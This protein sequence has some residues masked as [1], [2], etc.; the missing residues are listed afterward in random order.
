MPNV[1]SPQYDV[2]LSHNS[3]DKEIVTKIAE[4]LEDTAGL[5]SW[6]DEWELVPGKRWISGLKK[7]ITDV[8][9]IAVFIGNY[10]YGNWQG[11]EIEESL[12][13]EGARKDIRI[14]PVLLPDT[15]D[16]PDMYAFLDRYTWVNLRGGLED[17]NALWRLEC[18]IRGVPPG[19]GRDHKRI[20]PS[21]VSCATNISN[22]PIN[23]TSNTSAGY[24]DEELLDIL[25]RLPGPIFN[26][27]VFLLPKK[28]SSIIPPD[29]V[30]QLERS[31][32]LI[33]WADSAVGCGK[34]V[35]IYQLK[36]LIG[37]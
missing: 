5:K 30:A 15:P 29:T 35:L 20:S 26:Q 23:T 27:L 19:R 9:C 2:F 4:Y 10:G 34:D 12:I 8:P 37:K 1:E 13:I 31:T 6:L 36:K 25:C 18:G 3:K 17:D 7:A 21:D 16:N 11:I 14:I 22:T 32:K 24:S 28:S 33:E